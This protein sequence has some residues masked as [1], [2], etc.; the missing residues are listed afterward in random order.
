[1]KWIFKINFHETLRTVRREKQ[2]TTGWKGWYGR[3]HNTTECHLGPVTIS[4]AHFPA[5]FSY[6]EIHLSTKLSYL[7]KGTVNKYVF[8]IC[9]SSFKW[10]LRKFSFYF[11]FL[12]FFVIILFHIFTYIFFFCRWTLQFSSHLLS[13]YITIFFFNNSFGVSTLQLCEIL[14]FLKNICLTLS[15]QLYE[16][17]GP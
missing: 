17:T 12:L 6:S 1:M 13:D 15:L 5:G 8:R 10:R 16:Y 11:Y 4:S 9:I 3:G 14:V 2:K 7:F